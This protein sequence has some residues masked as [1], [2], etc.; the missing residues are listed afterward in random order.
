MQIAD[1]IVLEQRSTY[2][3]PTKAG[4]L[5]MLIILLMMIASTNYQNNLAFLLTF[6][7]CSIGIVSIVF[8]FKNL[9]G[10]AFEFAKNQS[11][12]A[13]EELNF[14]FHVS[15]QS[16]LPHLGIAVGFDKKS[17]F[18]LDLPSS[19]GKPYTKKIFILPIK[20]VKR[21]WFLVPKIVTTSCFPFGL[22]K[23]WSW[24]KFKSAILIYPQPIEPD[25]NV[26]NPIAN[27]KGDSNNQS[28]NVDSEYDGIR[29]YKVGDPISRVDWKAT[30]KEQGMYIKSFTSMSVNESA[31][32]WDDF[33]NVEKELRLSYLCYLVLIANSQKQAFSLSLPG[34]FINKD[35]G[36]HHLKKCLSTLALFKLD[37]MV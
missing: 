8:T 9:Q 19:D 20:A 6:L 28:N 21:G 4:F 3:L 32:N 15:S 29:A 13:G 34:Q 11:V 37:E 18:Y 7:I 33:S 24:F 35:S 30:A 2:I 17:L 26:L 22:L 1:R 5:L 23:V 14:N 25:E 16:G 36:E 10:L 12:F 31:F 27:D